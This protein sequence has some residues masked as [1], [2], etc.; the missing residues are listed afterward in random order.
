MTSQE[1][2]RLLILASAW[3][4]EQEKNILKDGI[5]LTPDQ[6]IDAFHIGV[7]EIPKVRLV[8]VGQIPLP[9]QPELRAAIAEAGLIG[10]NTI[11]IAFRWGI[12]IRD[13]YWGNRNLVVHELTHTSQYERYGGI[14]P[15]LK[16]YLQECL[17]EGYPNGPLELEAKKMEEKICD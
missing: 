6:Q 9:K 1:F 3:V 4:E 8:K 2:K 12:Y 17:L 10:S 15:F 5:P 7:K 11:G 13:D 16:D 14:E